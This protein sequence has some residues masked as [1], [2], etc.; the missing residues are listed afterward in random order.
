MSPWC[1]QR[2]GTHV[3]REHEGRVNAGAWD[4]AEAP[5]S[6][7]ER[8]ASNG[9][10]RGTG[11]ERGGATARTG[12]TVDPGAGTLSG[13][14]RTGRP[15]M[16]TL[17]TRGGGGLLLA[18][19]GHAVADAAL[20]G[21]VG[22]PV[23]IVAELAPHTPGEVAHNR[24]VGAPFR[25]HLA[26]QGGMGHDAARVAREHAQKLVFGGRQPHRAVADRSRWRGRRARTARARRVG[27]ARRARGRS[28]PSPRTAWRCSRRRRA[29][30]RGRRRTRSPE[31]LG[32]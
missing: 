17:A 1:V 4:N 11:A 18:Q 24:R 31:G 6:P 5:A 19:Q 16:R 3:E 32:E 2:L 29:P 26:Q 8:R 10:L 25:L 23:R 22:G 13:N 21:D 12:R 14:H 7:W 27:A 9:R 28:A 20:V 30:G 15:V